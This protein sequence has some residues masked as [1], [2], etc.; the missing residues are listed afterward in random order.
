MLCEF[1]VYS[2]VIRLYIFA[3]FKDEGTE[4][5]RGSLS[6]LNGWASPAPESWESEKGN[7]SRAGCPGDR[8][9]GCFCLPL[10]LL[11]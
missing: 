9:E 1:Q 6:R 2:R 10:P 8:G 3:H 4:A 7:W 5:G 11:F